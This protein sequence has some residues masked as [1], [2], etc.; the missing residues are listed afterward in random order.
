MSKGVPY[1]VAMS[2][3]PARRLA[4]IVLIGEAEGGH[5]DWRR[6]AWEKRGA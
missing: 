4:F 2:M 6:M 5:Y 3:S 1:D